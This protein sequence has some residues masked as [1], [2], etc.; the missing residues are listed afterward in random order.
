MPQKSKFSWIKSR[1]SHHPFSLHTWLFK[2]RSYWLL[3]PTSVADR[4]NI[5]LPNPDMR[6]KQYISVVKVPSLK[7]SVFFSRIEHYWHEKTTIFQT[8]WGKKESTEKPVENPDK[9]VSSPFRTKMI[10]IHNT[11]KNLKELHQSTPRA[12]PP[13]AVDHPSSLTSPG[14]QRVWGGG[15]GAA[16]TWSWWY[17]PPAGPCP[18]PAP[19][20]AGPRPAHP[21]GPR[22]RGRP[23]CGG[24]C[25]PG[26]GTPRRRRAPPPWSGYAGTPPSQG[27]RTFSQY[28]SPR[29]VEPEPDF[30]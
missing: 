4:S 8:K 6:E 17:P 28:T 3:L 9:I 18:D 15:R 16:S 23:A 14:P 22:P 10:Q 26:P 29:V 20:P 24:R 30:V 13:S 19:A 27:E 1:S 2:T 25:C 21:P 11:G 7:W 5:F 12:P